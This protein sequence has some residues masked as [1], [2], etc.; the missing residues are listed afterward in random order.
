YPVPDEQANLRAIHFMRENLDCTIGYSD[1][2]TGT[3]AAVLAIALGATIIE[4]HF[5]LDR[6][7]SDFRDHQLSAD[8]AGMR[9]LVQRIKRTELMLGK[10]SKTIQPCEEPAM[11]ALRR[12][13]VAGADLPAGHVIVA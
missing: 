6:H 12:G 5:T 2:T 1:H 10:D 7:Y 4:K 9:E 13:I 11:R 8:P 3:E